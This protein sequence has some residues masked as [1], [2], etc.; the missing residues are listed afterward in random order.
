MA[1]KKSHTRADLIALLKSRG[2]KGALSKMTKPQLK[3]LV[4]RSA[5]P[6]DGRAH[7]E[8]RPRGDLELEADEQGGGHFFRADGKTVTDGKHEHERKTWPSDKAPPKAKKAKAPAARKKKKDPLTDQDAEITV[9]LVNKRIN[10]SLH[11]GTGRKLRAGESGERYRWLLRRK[12]GRAAVTAED[13]EERLFNIDE[14]YRKEYPSDKKD[15]G[16][17]SEGNI[18]S[19]DR[20]R[21]QPDRLPQPDAFVSERADDQEG[22]GAGHSYRGWMKKNLKQYGGDMSQ[23]AAAYREQKGGH[24]ADVKGEVGAKQKSKYA[25]HKHRPAR[26]PVV[27]S[28]D[29][30]P[31]P[32]PAPDSPQRRVT[33]NLS[34]RSRRR[35]ERA[36]ESR[37]S[38]MPEQHG[39]GLGHWI[40]GEA[41][42]AWHG[43]TDEYHSS[44]VF[45]DVVDGAAAVGLGAIAATGIGAVGE[46][47]VGALGFGA[48]AGA[49]AVGVEGA[50]AAGAEGAAAAGAEGAEAG[51]AGLADSR[52]A[53]SG[54]PNEDLLDTRAS[55]ARARSNPASVGDA[56]AAG[57]ADAGAEGV[58]S[59]ESSEANADASKSMGDRVK[60]EATKRGKAELKTFG[61]KVRDK[62]PGTKEIIAG[63]G[64]ESANAALQD[65][66][67][68]TPPPS[69]PS[70]PTP[71]ANFFADR[72]EE[73]Q[74]SANSR[75]LHHDGP[76]GFGN[77]WYS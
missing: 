53:T 43:V 38:G 73:N 47:A 57:D 33:R 8:K 74:F 5:P 36:R 71:P 44:A 62:L 51:E 31:E 61:Q 26:N 24:Y 70:S 6:D 20:K 9:D 14:E 76:T 45:R 30:E 25:G 52:A 39:D 12:F 50:A 1:R 18:T 15:G 75:A 65:A 27:S 60:D 55:E 7:D 23:A 2:Q 22:E 17:V 21:K 3:A 4:D 56:A 16:A 40:A 32:A 13:L 35:L 29:D 72:Y 19:A 37:G 77:P 34:P 68:P 28:D 58:Q 54:G 63:I 42:G 59:A 10:A 11:P 67:T 41:K 49:A 48:E 66:E 64:T 46:L 69:P